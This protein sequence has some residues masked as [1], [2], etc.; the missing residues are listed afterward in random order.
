M[1]LLV[2]GI[3]P[4]SAHPSPGPTSC[5]SSN[6]TNSLCSFRSCWIRAD[7]QEEKE[8]TTP[9]S[10]LNFSSVSIIKIWSHGEFV[11]YHAVKREICDCDTES[12][13]SKA[14]LCMLIFIN[15]YLKIEEELGNYKY[16]FKL[17]CL[18]QFI[19]IDESVPLVRTDD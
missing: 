5:C 7:C 17:I 12:I 13:K 11:L 14:K 3:K 18:F 6:I 9:Q 4:K 10:S 1:R 16:N 8:K 19:L 2:T 15:Y